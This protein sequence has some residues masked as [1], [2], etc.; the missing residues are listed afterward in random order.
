MVS[1]FASFANIVITTIPDN[2]RALSA[3]KLSEK[4]YKYKI[5]TYV[6]NEISVAVEKAFQLCESNDNVIIISGSLYLVG[7]A[8]TYFKKRF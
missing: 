5:E 1:V 7:K 4:F 2:P 3:E 8:K 6:A